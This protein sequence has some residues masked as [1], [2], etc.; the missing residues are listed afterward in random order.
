MYRF[1]VS[2]ITQPGETIALAGSVP[3]M[4]SWRG[5]V[6]L[7]TSL[8]RY[9]I[10]SVDL[11]FSQDPAIDRIEYKYLRISP[12]GKVEWESTGPNRWIPLER[13]SQPS[14]IIVADGLFGE[15]LPYPYGYYAE[16]VPPTLSD[17]DTPG[18]RVVVL[19]SSVAMGCSAWLLR[20][21]AWQLGQAL[22]E[23]YD[24]RLVNVAE[25]GANVGT[26]IARF[27]RVVAP[28]HPEMVIIALSLGNE[29]LASSGRSQYRAIQRRF[30]SG[31]QQLIKMT[32]EL[33]AQPV[34]GGVY[35]HS[36]YSLE[37]YSILRETHDH[38]LSWGVPVFDWLDV[39]DDGQGR[40][41][42]GLGLDAAHPNTVGHN[43]MY[44]AID[45]SIFS[46]SP[47][48]PP[49]L[50]LS[51]TCIYQDVWGFQIWKTP[52]HI[53][54]HNGTEYPYKI[55]PEWEELQQALR[56]ANLM[57]G[58][59]TTPDPCTS[60]F[61]GE[62]G[63][64]GTSFS[65]PAATDWYFYPMLH[66]FSHCQVLFYDSHIGILKDNQ[67]SRIY[68]INESDHEYNVHPMWQ[69]VRSALKAMP[70]GVY[71]DMYHPEL[72]FRTMMVGSEGLESRV[73]VPAQSTIALDYSSSLAEISRVALV[74]LGDRCGARM[75]LYKL[76][77]DG[78]AFPFDLTR[79]TNLSDV[80]DIIANDFTDMWNPAY[81]HYNPDARRIYHGKWSG[82]SFAHEVEDTDNPVYDMS[83]IH[84]RMKTRY[85]ARA[86]R[87][88]YTL[89]AADK[90]LF[91]RTGLCDRP[92]VIDLMQKLS[93]K[94]AKPFRLM[95][96]S[97]QPS[98]EFEGLANVL[99]YDLEFNPDRMYEDLEHWL[100]CTKIMQE[101]LNSLG[102]SSKNLFWCPPNPPR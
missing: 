9:P 36:G 15:I 97:P 78:P 86:R 29:G 76:E 60:L 61:L 35:P 75:L 73:K 64:L 53:R 30:E 18:R 3:E 62:D 7:H 48:A 24:W 45:L 91:I 49:P 69:E 102:I 23:N 5:V 52:N 34:L 43:R 26:T 39:L 96:I 4:Q 59:Y 10:W 55:T 67:A 57:A 31:L 40:W 44:E 14:P 13:G 8:D 101:I 85:T 19:G 20:G 82:L 84:A 38:L 74:P 27:T 77:Y 70:P 25:L 99:H 21:W 83:P 92:A 80:A 88:T 65:I 50:N 47:T 42:P 87:F 98:A 63:S 51:E 100:Y 22:A 6:P 11:A 81:L 2:A 79:T 58:L 32:R 94:C 17:D 37:H 72:P 71:E 54:I 93:A 46:C 33:G 68:L 16:P 56:A 90:V 95:L 41:R 66:F 1:Q 28:Q 89:Q 12:D